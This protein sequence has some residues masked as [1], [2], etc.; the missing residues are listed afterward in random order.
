SVQ[1]GYLFADVHRK[2]N[3]IALESVASLDSLTNPPHRIGGE[4]VSLGVIELLDSSNQ[5][6]I[7][8]LDCIQQWKAGVPA[9]TGSGD[10]EPQIRP[11]HMIFGS[12]TVSCNGCQ[13]SSVD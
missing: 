7:S 10:D 5:P 8:F 4:F 9:F 1:L 13:V 6:Q 2:P 3:R 12:G 11:H